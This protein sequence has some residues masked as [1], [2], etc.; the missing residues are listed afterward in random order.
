MRLSVGDSAPH[1]QLP[2]LTGQSFELAADQA[3]LTLIAFHRFAGCP[4]CNL[5]LHQLIQHY[6]AW[7]GRLDVVVIFD[8]TLANLQQHATDHQPPFP[9]LADAKNTAYRAYGVEHS[10]W[11]VAKG[12]ICRLPTLL[13]AMRQGYLPKSLQGR[14]DTMP[15]SFIVD[16]HGTIQLAYY[17]QDEG[18]YLPLAQIDALLQQVDS[19]LK[20]G[21]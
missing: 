3:T 14:K 12:M 9:V 1:I 6:P 5:R 18:D 17:G 8:A 2:D 10:W 15:A 19:R 21:A 11:G 7:Q 4:F 20:Q 16:Q 13:Q